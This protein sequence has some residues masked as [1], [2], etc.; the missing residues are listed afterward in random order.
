VLEI[1]EFEA[2]AAGTEEWFYDVEVRVPGS[3][4]TFGLHDSTALFVDG[5]DAVVARIAS[6]FS[7][8]RLAQARS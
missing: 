8:T 1:G 6:A 5:E 4:I 7:D 2:L 3:S